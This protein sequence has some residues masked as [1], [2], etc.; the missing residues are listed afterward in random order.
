VTL[1]DSLLQRPNFPSPLF[2]PMIETLR[3]LEAAAE[4]SRALPSDRV[5]AVLLGCVDLSL[6]LGCALEWEPLLY[7]RSRVIH[8]AALA[9][10]GVIDSPY[11]DVS[12]PAALEEEA[13]R[14]ARLGFMGKSAIH[15]SQLAPIH[16]AFAPSSEQL[17]RARA[18]VEAFERMAGGVALLDGKLIERPVY[19]AA[20]R[21]LS[22][23]ESHRTAP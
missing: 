19:L 5:L 12:N 17:A 9:G 13:R 20:K 21:L 7:A 11:L 15:P 22:S 8:A 2:L 4:I 16:R 10:A 14:S 3:G 6:E 18:V 1:L 23:A